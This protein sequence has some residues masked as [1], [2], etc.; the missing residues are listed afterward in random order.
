M[1]S[2]VDKS[3]H[4]ENIHLNVVSNQFEYQSAVQMLYKNNIYHKSIACLPVQSLLWVIFLQ[5]KCEMHILFYSK[6]VTTL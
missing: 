3:H 2:K 4:L 1:A 5:Q 6:S